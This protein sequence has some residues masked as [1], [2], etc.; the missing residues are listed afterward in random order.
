MRL[1]SGRGPPPASCAGNGPPIEQPT[2]TLADGFSYNAVPSQGAPPVLPRE[3]LAHL[4]RKIHRLGE[5]P[6]FELL[7]DLEDGAEFV[8][9]LERYAEV[10]RYADFIRGLGSDRLPP[11]RPVKCRP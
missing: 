3:R 2:K 5:R 9:T 7:R 8:P 10:E 1:G 11:V 4:A 6:L